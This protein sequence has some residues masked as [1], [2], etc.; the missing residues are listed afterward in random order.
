MM[1][2]P[3]SL[4]FEDNGEHQSSSEASLASDVIY[5]DSPVCPRI[6]SEHQAE[7][8][9][10][11]TEDERRELMAS[12]H[13]DSILHG[14]GYPVVVGLTLPIIWA[15]PREASKTE[16]VLQMQNYSES[17]TKGSTGDVQSQVTS[18]CATSNDTGRCDPTFQD[19]HAVVP[20][21]QIKS[22][23]NQAYN[24]K[25][26][27]CPSQEGQNVTNNSIMQQRET[28]QLNPLPYSPIA[29]WS[30][31]E[32]EIF[33]LGLYIF[34]KNL[35][36]LS[37]FLGTKTVGD[38]L[39]YY[40]GKFYR[41][42]AYKRWSDCRKAKTRKCILGER[43]FQGWRQ[44]ELISRL[45]SK[46]PKE[47]HDSLIEVFKSFSD[48]QTSLKEFVFSLKSTV[49]AETFVEAVG[50]GKGKHD[51]TGFIMDQSKPNQALSVHSDLP[52]GKDYSSLASEDIIKFLNGDFRRS[53]TRSNYIFWEA[54]WPRLLANGWHSEQPKD[55]STTKNC[56]VFLVPGIKKF[57]RCKLTKGTHYF[58]SVSDVLKRVAAD[59]VLLEL[60]IDVIN[61]GLTAEENGSITDVKL[62]QYSPLDGYQELPKFTIIDTSLVEGEVPFNVRELRNLPADSNISFLLSQH[63]SNMVSYSS[64]EEE[65][66]NDRLSDE[67][68][69]YGRVKAV[70][71]EIE[72][73]SAASLQNMVT[74]NGNDDKLDLTGI[75]TK[76][77]KR[78]YL[79][80][81]SKGRMLNSCSNEQASRRSFS[82]SKGGDLEKEK[83]KPPL[84]S[85]KPAAL[86]VGDTFQSYSTKDNLSEQKNNAL[87]S[88]TN[89]G[90]NE[91]MV[92]ENL[93][94]KSSE[95]KV[96]AVAEVHSKINADQ[97]KFIKE[98]AE[99]VGPIDLNNLGTLH[100]DKASRSIHITS[101]ENL[102]SVKVV[103]AS[104]SSDKNMACDPSGTAGMPV[105]EVPDP[106]L[107]V[108]ARRHGTRN[109]P[110][111]VKAL[112]AVAFGLLGSGK[113]KG[114]MKN[115]ATS[116]PSQRARK[117]AKDSVPV[118]S[119]GDAKV[120]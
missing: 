98:R 70:V 95:R 25:M 48:S 96:D 108:N 40:Y 49:G 91:R 111:T 69:D 29:L 9:N 2:E 3:E 16:Q 84:T 22:D 109:R 30:D 101:F 114:D 43:I 93:I 12:S 37:R 31:L 26:A 72:M 90:Q 32:A 76:P 92:M 85:S 86:E 8:P 66:A 10:L 106:A 1:M 54:V 7:I 87:N 38:V 18:T 13:N 103:E 62:N 34:G 27:P 77:E 28:K 42:D 11:A 39:A 82:F 44:Q 89:Y 78:K 60:E 104:S 14:Y 73:V 51:L 102:G 20:V 81:V 61:N 63:P 94:N 41:R 79:S 116:R 55:V 71:D 110:P 65:G 113:R 118:A 64:S 105:S 45:K 107:Q 67:Q 97:P 75:K 100:G 83:S 115:R 80:P 21:V 4:D 88:L 58:D 99:V 112:E 17:G 74:A 24:E 117:A 33:L 19:L 47:A 119:C 50:V 120:R 15:S 56:L 59:P 36:L 68:E 57:S 23:I 6:G 46:I 35:N 5:G 52:T 53:K